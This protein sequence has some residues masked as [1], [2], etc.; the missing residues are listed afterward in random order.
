MSGRSALD[1]GSSSADI[2][3]I[4]TQEATIKRIISAKA[5]LTDVDAVL[6]DQS[7]QPVQRLQ[8]YNW[9]R[10]Q[11][12]QISATR[13]HRLRRSPSSPLHH[14]LRRRRGAGAL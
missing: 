1:A 7:T 13:T 14:L 9:A 2:G 3:A 10:I 4:S 11:R 8:D 12:L 5:G 6:G